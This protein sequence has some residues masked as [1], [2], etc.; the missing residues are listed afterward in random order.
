MDQRALGQHR[1]VVVRIDVVDHPVE[2]EMIHVAECPLGAIRKQRLH[3]HGLAA[4]VH[5]R[6]E[7]FEARGVSQHLVAL[8]LR[9]RIR[10]DVEVVPGR[11]R[12]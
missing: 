2:V 7:I 6:L 11:R 1:R 5:M 12:E 10:R 4:Q 8:G 9:D 3:Q